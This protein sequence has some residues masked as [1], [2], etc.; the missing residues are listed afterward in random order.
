MYIV[1]IC[2]SSVILDRPAEHM[3]KV[4]R[5]QEEVN[6]NKIESERSSVKKLINEEK[7][8]MSV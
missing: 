4:Y 1:N 8:H 6:W 7:N 3:K 5:K 2:G